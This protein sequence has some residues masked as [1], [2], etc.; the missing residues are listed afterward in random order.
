MNQNGVVMIDDARLDEMN[1][2]AHT[3]NTIPPMKITSPASECF[4]MSASVGRDCFVNTQ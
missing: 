3:T 1:C 4:P 2:C